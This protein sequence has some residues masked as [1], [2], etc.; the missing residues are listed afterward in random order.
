MDRR[1]GYD[2][3]D[4][5]LTLTF[6]G[7]AWITSTHTSLKTTPQN[8]FTASTKLVKP[9]TPNPTKYTSTEADRHP[10]S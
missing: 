5:V 1:S 9:E 4:A 3:S 6:P 10:K 7:L 8:V 2:T